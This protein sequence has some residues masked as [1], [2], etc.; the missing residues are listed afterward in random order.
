[1]RRPVM[2]RCSYQYKTEDNKW[3]NIPMTHFLLLC[4]TQ[5]GIFTLLS[6]K[7]LCEKMFIYV[8]VYLAQILDGEISLLLV[9][10]LNPKKSFEINLNIK[11]L[12]WDRFE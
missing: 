12:V 10:F 6:I 3:Q 5:N 9:F 4:E 2:N 7:V 8:I 1:M 11:K